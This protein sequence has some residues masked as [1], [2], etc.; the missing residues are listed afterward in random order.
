MCF[1]GWFFSG[2]FE[3]QRIF[4]WAFGYGIRIATGMRVGV[5]VCD[6]ILC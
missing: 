4:V 5:V 3:L 1:V 6:S 2:C